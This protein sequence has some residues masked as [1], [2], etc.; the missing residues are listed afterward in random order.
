[1]LLRLISSFTC[2]G[3]L[4]LCL[5]HLTSR[6]I[7]LLLATLILFLLLQPLLLLLPSRHPKLLPAQP[8]PLSLH[9]WVTV[10]VLLVALPQ[11]HHCITKLWDVHPRQLLP[12]A[13]PAVAR[14]RPPILPLR[15]LR[16][17]T[18]CCTCCS[19]L[20]SSCI[21][22]ML[23]QLPVLL[24]CSGLTASSR[25][26]SS[27]VQPPPCSPLL[28]LPALPWLFIITAEPS[29]V[30]LLLLLGAAAVAVWCPALAPPDTHLWQQQ[31]LL[32]RIRCSL[33]CC[34]APAST[35]RDPHK[36][37]CYRCD[38]NTQSLAA[39]TSSC[40]TAYCCHNLVFSSLP[41]EPKSRHICVS[42]CAKHYADAMLM[43]SITG[44]LT[45]TYVC[46]RDRVATPNGSS[47][48]WLLS[49]R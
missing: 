16:V 25:S 13:Q 36:H 30:L 5:L 47:S 40:S 27:R 39:N 31:V 48:G 29:P 22:I 21:S 14:P 34:T 3:L 4:L 37:L 18:T 42:S 44:S 45:S 28:L 15:P 26:S 11:V 49:P 32:A 23:P 20:C 24:S 38:Q 43:S 33:C 2:Q 6:V 41:C 19:T 7:A 10:K 9:T 46:G 17:T 8:G 12:A 1:M 35:H